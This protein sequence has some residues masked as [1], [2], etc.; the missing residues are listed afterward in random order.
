[1]MK[2]SNAG[3]GEVAVVLSWLEGSELM[4]RGVVVRVGRDEA[5]VD[6]ERLALILLREA[7]DIESLPVEALARFVLCSEASAIL[8]YFL[9]TGPVCSTTS[10]CVDDS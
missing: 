3:G 1:M 9:L 7:F 4:Y 5:N 2:L 8:P 6:G 10:A